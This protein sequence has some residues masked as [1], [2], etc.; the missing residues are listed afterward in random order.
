METQCIC[1]VLF[2]FLSFFHFFWLFLFFVAKK[3]R[4]CPFLHSKSSLKIVSSLAIEARFNKGL[5]RH[6]TMT[7]TLLGSAA[8]IRR[9]HS[10]WLQIWN[11]SPEEAGDILSTVI[12]KFHWKRL[13][14]KSYLNGVST[15]R[16]A[17]WCLPLALSIKVPATL[18]MGNIQRGSM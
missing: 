12:T 15:E 18:E 14:S 6:S 4:G 8:V 2:I 7:R 3:Q 16:S 1:H 17:K 9:L 13:R 11:P 5:S 10:R